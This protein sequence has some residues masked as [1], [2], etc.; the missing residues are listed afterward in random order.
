MRDEEVV[1]KELQSFLESENCPWEAGDL[2]VK[3]V[4][5]CVPRNEYSVTLAADK[6]EVKTFISRETLHEYIDSGH[7]KRIKELCSW[8]DAAS[9]CINKKIRRDVE[10]RKKHSKN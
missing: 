6:Y 10:K 9:T 7:I 1:K 5:T 2:E 3:E 4:E 8:A